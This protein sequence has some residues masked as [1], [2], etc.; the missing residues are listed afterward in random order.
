MRFFVD[1]QLPPVLKFWL[2]QQGHDCVHAIDLP[3]KDSTPDIEIVDFVTSE[4][5]ILISK[6]SDFLKLK[7]LTG[8]PRQLLIITTGN[9]KN[10]E[11][12]ATFERNFRSALR[13]FES[14]EVI[15]LGNHFVTGRN[16]GS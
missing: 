11:L 15:E 9:I 12:I 10:V 16:I 13:L 2:V 7:L 8:S 6:D 4:N 1:A 5:R 14:F 3:K